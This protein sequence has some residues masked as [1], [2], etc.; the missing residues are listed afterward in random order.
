MKPCSKPG[1]GRGVT[2][3]GMCRKHYLAAWRAGTMDAAPTRSR[4][5]PECPETHAHDLETCWAEHGCRCAQCRH[6]RKMERQRRRNRLRAYGR[7]DQI[8]PARVPAG[9]VRDRLVELQ[10]AGFGLERVADAAQVPRSAVMDIYF[11]PRGAGVQPKPI[12]ERVTRASHAARLLAVDPA[13]IDAAL[14]PSTGTTRRLQALVAV[15]Y[16]ETEIAQRLGMDVTNLSTLMHDGRPRVLAATFVS[17][18]SVFASLW[19]EPQSGGWADNARRVAKRHGWAGPLAWD[20]I[21]DPAERPNTIGAADA[22][23]T[24]DETAVELALTGARVRLTA[25]ERR[26]AVTRAHARRWSDTRIAETLHI[27]DRTVLRIRQDL[28]LEAFEY[29]DLVKAGAA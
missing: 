11:G 20:D 9:P 10:D 14:V 16:T 4:T 24:I 2:A 27:A 23:P 17:V 21:D 7:E 19:A 3:R 18:R 15:G 29:S 26:E 8:A 13:Q 28:G 12:S 6:L 5:L 25:L 22:E 1:C